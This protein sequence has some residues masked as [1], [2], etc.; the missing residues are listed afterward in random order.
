MNATSWTASLLAKRAVLF[1]D[2]LE[3]A[4]VVIHQVHLVDG[5]ED[6]R[7]LQQRG[8]E[9]VPLGLGEHPLARVDQDDRQLRSGRAGD[10]VARVLDVAGRIRNDELAP[11]GGEVAVGDIDG[12]GL[13]TLGAQA[14]GEQC[15]VQ[16]G[17]AALLAGAFHRR[18]GVFQDGLAVEQQPADQRALA[19]VHAA[20]GGEAEKVAGSFRNTPAACGL[21]SP[22][23][24]DGRRHAC[25]AR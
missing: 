24:R 3:D 6:V 19:V 13:F 15:Q 1:H 16:I 25:R 7:D 20:G 18:Q 9:A 4:L 21:P 22:S 2:G 12:D 14:I 10:H 11:R 8:Q 5:D 17:I 23:R